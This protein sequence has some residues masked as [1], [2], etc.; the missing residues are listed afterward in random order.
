MKFTILKLLIVLFFFNSNTALAKQLFYELLPDTIYINLEPGNYNKYVFKTFRAFTDGDTVEKINIRKKYKTWIN[1]KVSS[2]NKV[3]FNSKIKIMGDWKDHIKFDYI[4]NVPIT[5]LKIKIIDNGSI[6]GF[7]KFRLLLPETRLNE[8]EIFFTTLLRYINFPSYHT[9]LVKVIFNGNVYF[10]LL[11]EDASKEFLERSGL[12][13]LPI[14]KTNEFT[15]YLNKKSADYYQ[16]EKI[17]KKHFILYNKDFLKK[18][19][20]R[21]IVSDAIFLLNTKNYKKYIYENDFFELILRKYASH[22]LALHNRRFIYLPYN[23]LFIPLYYDGMFFPEDWVD[24]YKVCDLEIYSNKFNNF[25]DEY[26]TLSGKKLTKLQKCIYN[27]VIF[28]YKLHKKDGSFFKIKNSLLNYNFDKNYLFLKKLIS[29]QLIN[30]K[31]IEN[32]DNSYSYTF[33]KNNSYYKCYLNI[34]LTNL[35]YCNILNEEEYNYYISSS[36]I[37]YTNDNDISFNNINLGNLDFIDKFE[38]IEFNNNINQ[39]TLDK[40]KIYILN[41]NLKN[42]NINFNLNNPK[43]KLIITGKY[44]DTKFKF[45]GNL[46]N[47][48]FYGFINQN[49]NDR[50]YLNGCVNFIN[51]EVKNISIIF[52]NSYCEDSINFIKS[53]GS[54]SNFNVKN[55]LFDAVDFDFSNLNI[56]NINI[57]NAKNDCI[58]V[59]FGN[60]NFKNIY[61]INC[62]DKGISVGE[63]SKVNVNFVSIKNS[64]YGLVSKDSSELLINTFKGNNIKEFCLAAYNKKD[65]FL[66]GAIFYKNFKCDNV[67]YNDNQSIIK[68]IN[69]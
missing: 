57:E 14:L 46:K 62:N 34:N 15:F 50:N 17:L 32:K 33:I 19:F 52:D 22:G 63:K 31:N 59:S 27:E 65:E 53:E 44:E 49:R 47:K 40:D 67:N 23:N 5:S 60:Y 7:K 2:N 6:S 41:N 35:N 64:N 43:S 56:N 68:Q 28:L 13:E 36:T 26:E 66:G 48:N 69:G 45:Y 30:K 38:I 18:P 24:E 61:L 4:S 37:A 55:S 42:K 39:Y 51:T 9:K 8:N 29:S 58:D 12:P 16:N 10:A 25:K 54:I 21:E 3:F 20:S 1:A 11:Q